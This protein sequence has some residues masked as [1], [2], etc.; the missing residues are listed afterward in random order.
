[1]PRSCRVPRAP[2]CR[3]APGHDR[4]RRVFYIQESHDPETLL[5]TGLRFRQ[6]KSKIGPFVKLCLHPDDR[7]PVI[8]TDRDIA[9]EEYRSVVQCIPAGRFVHEEEL[10][11][12]HAK[13]IAEITEVACQDTSAQ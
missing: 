4:I 11:R 9:V 13:V 12:R 5:N 3:F 10:L 7:L 1:M 2:R 6:D 8:A